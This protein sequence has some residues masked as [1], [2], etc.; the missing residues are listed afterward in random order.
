[1]GQLLR[2]FRSRVWSGGEA[3]PASGPDQVLV[4]SGRLQPA[5]D[6]TSGEFAERVA[7]LKADVLRR[8]LAA[9]EDERGKEDEPSAEDAAEKTVSP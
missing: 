6:E 1:M 4:S 8:A 9:I 5:E 7:R 3:P 2:W